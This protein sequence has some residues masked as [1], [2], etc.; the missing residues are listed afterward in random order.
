MR[1]RQ[2]RYAFNPNPSLAE[3]VRDSYRIIGPFA[4]LII[5]LYQLTMRRPFAN[6][7]RLCAVPSIWGTVEDDN[8]RIL[9][10]IC[11]AYATG[12]RDSCRKRS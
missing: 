9:R 8:H 6:L 12:G 1:K 3:L 2:A 5:S 7:P 10:L 11:V 4:D